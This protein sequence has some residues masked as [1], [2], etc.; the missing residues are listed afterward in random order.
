MRFITAIFGVGILSAAA[1]FGAW[2]AMVRW[3]PIDL[4][5]LKAD[6]CKASVVLDDEGQELFRF[7]RDRRE[8]ISLALLP[9]HVYQAFVAIEDRS[10]FTHAGISWRG[11]IRSMIVNVVRGR[12]AQGASTITQQLVRMLFLTTKKTFVRKIKE[13]WCALLIE[14]RYTK[15]QILE[16]YLNSV[17]FGCGI[18]GIE[19]AA[20]RF[21]GISA[22]DISIAQAAILAAIVC[23]PAN[24]NPLL[25]PQAALDR[26][27]VVLHAMKKTGFIS[28]YVY[29]QTKKE[30]LK[31]IQESLR[32][33]VALYLKEAIA[34][35]F[36][37]MLD[38]ASLY[39]GGYVIQTTLSASMQMV[40][41]N[42]FEA[43]GLA[44][45]QKLACNIDGGLISMSAKDGAIKA[46][47]GAID[48]KVSHFNRAFQ[49]HRQLGSVIKP[50][51]YAAALEHDMALT[52]IEHDEPLE[53]VCGGSL[54]SPHNYDHT[55]SGPMTRAYALARSNNI[56]SIKTLLQVGLGQFADIVRACGLCIE[57]P[58]PS[59]ALGCI[60]ATALQVAGMFNVFAHDGV[61]I[62]P[63]LI[64]WIKDR[65]GNKLYQYQVVSSSIFSSKTA[66]QILSVLT[67]VVDRLCA[68]NKLSHEIQA[69][70]KSGTTND[71]RTCWFVGSTPS[72]TTCVYLGRDDNCSMGKHV[73][74]SRT[75]FPI[76][77]EF[78][79]Q[80]SSAHERFIC[81]P[82]LC[83][84]YINVRT[85]QQVAQGSAESMRIL[86]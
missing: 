43:H 73:Y 35:L 14:Q 32:S 65:W 61:Y 40:A 76:W 86:S 10:F 60:D 79:R 13:Q 18:Y 4:T 84:T 67:N 77:Y 24:Y 1:L 11:I 20:Q 17:Y 68:L 70:G 12:C 5:A 9:P 49:A 44:L 8:P 34:H 58:Y 48:A 50:L 55:F 52:D 63:Y 71:W 26:R 37:S 51:I 31:I 66:H 82:R 33:R 45:R 59:L 53:I 22:Q 30:P 6:E 78:M 62:K 28:S 29:K 81:D 72:L 3:C 36:E 69:I 75:A 38:R 19:A 42:I 21:W 27:N 56:V 57:Q 85:G 74:P 41:Q 83:E 23:S 46:V 15:Y 47:V 16:A 54:W 39:E 64:S 25:C 80:M 2:S 7:A